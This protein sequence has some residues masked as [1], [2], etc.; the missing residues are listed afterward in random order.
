MLEKNINHTSQ[1]ENNG[2]A[3]YNQPHLAHGLVQPFIESAPHL[4]SPLSDIALG[5][6]IFFVMD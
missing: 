3:H 5:S 6:G 4:S 1:K 2:H